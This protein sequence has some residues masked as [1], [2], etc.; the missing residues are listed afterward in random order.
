MKKALAILLSFVMVI[1]LFSFNL[2]SAAT[3][4][5]FSEDFESYNNGDS[6][7]SGTSTQWKVYDEGVD[8]YWKTHTVGEDG[9]FDSNVIGIDKGV[10]ALMI[11]NYLSNTIW[12]IFMDIDY[13]QDGLKE[14]GFRKA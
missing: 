6:L 9:W 14:L 1:T 2:T 4:V 10:S 8:G 11:E 7:T 5:T 12:N 13:V 3:I